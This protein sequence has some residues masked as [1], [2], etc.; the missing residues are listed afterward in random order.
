LPPPTVP[1]V[2]PSTP[3]P[4]TSQTGTGPILSYCPGG[5]GATVYLTPPDPLATA[6]LTL[7]S[8]GVIYWDTTGDGM[9]E[10]LE[11]NLEKLAKALHPHLEKLKKGP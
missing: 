11:A 4:C 3:D 5:G 6:T 1:P 2:P 9:M 8:T 10:I 7:D